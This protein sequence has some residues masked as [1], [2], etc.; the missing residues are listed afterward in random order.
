ME[1]L[2]TE[3][4]AGKQKLIETLMVSEI[5]IQISQNQKDALSQEEIKEGEE[6][7][8][9]IEDLEE[10][11]KSEELP[12]EKRH[13]ELKEKVTSLL[14]SV[15]TIY[16]KRNPNLDSKEKKNIQDK[17]EKDKEIIEDELDEYI[18]KLHDGSISNIEK[19][20]SLQSYTNKLLSTVQSNIKKLAENERRKKLL[21]F[22]NKRREQQK[23]SQ[24]K[25]QDT[26]ES[27]NDMKSNKMKVL[28]Y[29]LFYSSIFFV[30]FVYFNG[31]VFS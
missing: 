8:S 11:L 28:L 22:E 16:L 27:I 5:D 31:R 26:L 15:N 20:N 18:D 9:S 29:V 10:E 21:E 30:L 2:K 17:Y 24:M 1:E 4:N 13:N 12:E 6:K 23:Y 19:M 14:Q 25:T 7:E 3:R